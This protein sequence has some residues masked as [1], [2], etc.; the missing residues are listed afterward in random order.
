MVHCLK[1]NG[2]NDCFWADYDPKL[3]KHTPVEKPDY[4]MQKDPRKAPPM[5]REMQ[6]CGLG[7]NE[8][9]GSGPMG[10]NCPKHVLFEVQKDKMAAENAAAEEAERAA[11]SCRTSRKKLPENITMF[12]YLSLAQETSKVA[13]DWMMDVYI[14]FGD[15]DP[16][17]VLNLFASLNDMNIRGRQIDVIVQHW[18]PGYPDKM[19]E[20]F[21]KNTEAMIKGIKA[22]PASFVAFIN[23][24]YSG[25]ENE[26]AVV[27]GASKYGHLD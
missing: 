1:P 7:R 20:T 12:D 24:H 10:H 13:Y 9:R 26:E 21:S 2:D 15:V 22:D 11:F 5:V 27:G 3:R 17:A 16:Q 19:T 25:S 14:A 6:G 23:E 18:Y 4:L 8:W